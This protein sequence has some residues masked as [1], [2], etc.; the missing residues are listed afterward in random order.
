MAKLTV[1][2]ELAII[3][4][5]K[6]T[7]DYY[8]HDGIPCARKWPA[9]PGHKRAPAVEAQWD[10]FS[11]ATKLWNYQSEEIHQAYA[12]TAAGTNLSGRDLSQK[13]YIS[14]YLKEE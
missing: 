2:P 1:L 14:G 11:Y 7:I 10:A 6:G 13:A 9:S 3:D 8:V 5:M 4:M 12:E